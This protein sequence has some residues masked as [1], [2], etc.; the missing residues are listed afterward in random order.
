MMTDDELAAIR[1]RHKTAKNRPC[2]CAGYHVGVCETCEAEQEA[3]DDRGLLLAEVERLRLENRALAEAGGAVLRADLADFERR[4][5]EVRTRID[6][7]CR[8][9]DPNLP[10]T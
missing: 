3:V 5:A 10:T 2:S 9:T 4:R 6:R 1:A 8:M 7:G